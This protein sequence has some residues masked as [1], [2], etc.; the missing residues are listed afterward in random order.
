MNTDNCVSNLEGVSLFHERPN[1]KP[2]KFLTC[3]VERDRSYPDVPFELLEENNLTIDANV[4]N[5]EGDPISE[6]KHLYIDNSNFKNAEELNKYLRLW[7][8]IPEFL[9]IRSVPGKG[10]G[11]FTKVDLFPD[12]YLSPYTGIP[13]MNEVGTNPANP[14][15]FYLLDFH[16]NICGFIDASNLTFANVTRFFN[17]SDTPNCGGY[18]I[19][20]AI[21]YKTYEFVKAGEELTVNYGSEYWEELEKFGIKKC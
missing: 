13:R 16:Q 14:Y 21:W 8:K 6:N 1:D 20:M 10:Y 5:E 17:H 7:G 12:T 2:I 18:Q 4:Y 15:N 9:E 19:S 3:K 11:V